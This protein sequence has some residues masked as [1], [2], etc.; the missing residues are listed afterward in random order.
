M[1]SCTIPRS[2]WTKRKGYESHEH[3]HGLCTLSHVLIYSAISLQAKY[4][5]RLDHR[6]HIF[7]NLNGAKDEVEIKMQ[8]DVTYAYNSI[9]DTRATVY[10]GNGPSKV[11]LDAVYENSSAVL[12]LVIVALYGSFVFS[13]DL[14]E[15][16]CQLYPQ[17]VEQCYWLHSV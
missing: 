13:S 15:Q 7:Q 10:H 16:S 6:A 2:S 4:S 1:T 11:I 9:Y 14:P 5:I 3:T 12:T 17:C 8:G